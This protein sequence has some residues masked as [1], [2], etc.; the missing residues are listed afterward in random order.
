MVG[1]PPRFA[2]VVG[3]TL[4]DG[5]SVR[6][7]HLRAWA[8]VGA[9]V[10]VNMGRYVKDDDELER[11]SGH[12]MTMVGLHQSNDHSEIVFHNP[13]DETSDLMTQSATEDK[14]PHW[15]TNIGISK[16]TGRRSQG[17]ETPPVRFAL[18]TDTSP[19]PRL[20]H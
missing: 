7:E 8:T 14:N 13:D 17:G 9:L 15:R 18:S 1:R 10:N 4:T 5:A 12:R 20:S 16:A 2:L 3:A 6:I 19:S 11:K